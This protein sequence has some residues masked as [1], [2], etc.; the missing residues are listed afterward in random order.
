MRTLALLVTG[1]GDAALLLPA[2]A[3]FV[4]YLVRM[5]AWPAVAAWIS[6]LAL[7]AVTTVAAKM[8]FHACGA[9]FPALAMRS[10]SGHTSLSTTFYCCGALAL[11]AQQS[12]GRRLAALCV[13]MAVAVAIAAS[14]VVLHAHTLEEVVAGLSIGLVC[15]AFFALSNRP[16]AIGVIGWRLP[17]ATVLAL[18]LLTHGYH[19]NLERFL[20]RVSDRLQLAGHLCP[21]SGEATVRNGTAIISSSLSEPPP[22]PD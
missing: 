11:A 14:R 1:L 10:P 12:R 20:D 19:V 7:C 6:A 21:V 9:Q 13:A 5:R 15:V 16:R 18:A 3:V 17:I 2:A 22:R 8:V 4:L